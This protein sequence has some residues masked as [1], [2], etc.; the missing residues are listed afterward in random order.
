MGNS[1]SHEE[2]PQEGTRGNTSADGH[3]GAETN[4][5]LGRLRDIPRAAA[6]T[7]GKAHGRRSTRPHNSQ[8]TQPAD[9]G[10]IQVRSDASLRS[11]ALDAL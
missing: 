8:P 6:I 3:I 1:P 11:K 4:T 9:F 10:F 7:E 2:L 5:L